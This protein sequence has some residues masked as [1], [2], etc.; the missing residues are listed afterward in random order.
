MI[1][2]PRAA[3]A[4][5][6]DF[7]AAG[8]LTAHLV[9]DHAWL[10]GFLLIPLTQGKVAIIDE[11]D[12]GLIEPHRWHAKHRHLGLWYA[13]CTIGGRLVGMHQLILPCA[14]GFTPDHIDGDGLNN[15]R[16]NLRPATWS[17]QRA[18]TN[19][20]RHRRSPFKGVSWEPR[21]GRPSGGLW[22]ANLVVNGVRY[23]ATGSTEEEAARL[24]NDLARE[25][26]GEFAR[27]NDVGESA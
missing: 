19:G 12:R 7:Q 13:R 26:H 11:V 1:T 10:P 27:L 24:Y 25:H 22:R 8:I 17:Q 9:E 23:R 14:P 16:G 21:P 20:M 18:N 6:P 3:G 15:R 5:P 2:C 4:C